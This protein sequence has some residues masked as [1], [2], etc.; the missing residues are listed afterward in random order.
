MCLVTYISACIKQELFLRSLGLGFDGCGLRRIQVLLLRRFALRWTLRLALGLT[1]RATLGIPRLSV[2]S[3]AIGIGADWLALA[4]R[5]RG[6]RLAVG[7]EAWLLRRARGTRLTGRTWGT[8]I[9]QRL[10]VGTEARLTAATGT[11]AAEVAAITTATTG[12]RTARTAIATTFTDGTATPAG[13][14]RTTGTTRTAR[15]TGTATLARTTAAFAAEVARRCGQLPADTGARQLAATRTIVFLLLFFRRAELQA[16]EAA[17]LR[18]TAIAAEATAA[19]TTTPSTAIAA[20][21]AAATAA[22]TAATAIIARTAA[23]GRT[24][25]AIDDVVEL[26]ARDRVVRSLLA[27]KHA[28]EAHLIDAIPD[29]VER[30]DQARCAIGL[31]AQRRRERLDMRIVLGRCRC[32]LGHRGLLFAARLRFA[33]GGRIGGRV[34]S[35]GLAAVTAAVRFGRAI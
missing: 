21:A 4:A 13:T 31:D 26:A 1:L 30:F 6:Q 18:R 12:T 2:R 25:D 7:T 35:S 8:L 22:I 3:E 24:R 23:A 11:T 27:L 19:A 28:H 14:T 29:D 32:A 34:G 15:T 33:I 10:T 20:A 16:A 17:R 9:G 5:L